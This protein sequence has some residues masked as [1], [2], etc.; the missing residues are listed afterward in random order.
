[1]KFSLTVCV[2]ACS[3]RFDRQFIIFIFYKRKKNVVTFCSTSFRCFFLNKLQDIFFSSFFYWGFSYWIHVGGREYWKMIDSILINSNLSILSIL[4]SRSLTS[5]LLFLGETYQF[6]FFFS[7][8]FSKV[9]K[10]KFASCLCL[11]CV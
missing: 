2:T 8:L 6:P 3:L 4:R 11:L 7:F 1:M 10:R 9:E 5:L